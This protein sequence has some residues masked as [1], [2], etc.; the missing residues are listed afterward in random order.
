[1]GTLS[2]AMPWLVTRSKS[3]SAVDQGHCGNS[4]GRESRREN[5][6]L[7]TMVNLVGFEV[8]IHLTSR[9][10]GSISWLCTPFDP[11]TVCI[12]D[13]RC[14]ASI[15]MFVGAFGTFPRIDISLE[16]LLHPLS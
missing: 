8:S 1:M 11:N 12:L 2:Q 4:G 6:L 10:M 15:N 9:T 3:S 14:M 13:T 7:V 5:R 16:I